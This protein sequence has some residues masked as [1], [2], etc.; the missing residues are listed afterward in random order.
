MLA[1]LAIAM[2]LW[3]NL[4][5]GFLLG[6]ALTIIYFVCELLAGLCLSP[7]SGGKSALNRARQYF[8]VLAA[9]FVASLANPYGSKLLVYI[10]HYMQSSQILQVTN[11]FESPVFHGALQPTCLEIL[12]FTFVVS[13]AM[14]KKR[15][16]FPHLIACLAFGHLALSGIR[17]APE[18]V[19]VVL[20]FIANLSSSVRFSITEEQETQLAPWLKFLC[21]KLSAFSKSFDQNESQCQMHLLPIASVAVFFAAACNS[22]SLFGQSILHDGFASTN[23]PTTTLDY[24]KDKKL[25]PTQGFNYDNWG[26]Y[27]RYRIGIPV[28]IDDRLD[29]YGKK[30]YLDYGKIVLLDPAWSEILDRH[31]IQWIIFPKNGSLAHILS[32]DPH[33]QLAAQDAA[34][35][36]FVRK[37]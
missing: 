7:E 8:L 10:A 37:K 14:T 2:A 36:L 6:F 31:H 3:V 26:G 19:I 20:P 35:N 24:I 5:P 22:G 12:F 13:L 34:A 15:P 29:F 30:F 33:W 16:S 18:F 23:M 4:H 17:N 27:I 1:I 32:A 25:L 21:V 11:E 9:L 28:F